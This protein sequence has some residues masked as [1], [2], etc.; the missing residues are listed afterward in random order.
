MAVLDTQ[1]GGRQLL[2]RTGFDG[3]L[4]KVCSWYNSLVTILFECTEGLWLSGKHMR[5]GIKDTI[6]GIYLP[7][8]RQRLAG[9]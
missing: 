1:I 9:L 3:P 2:R 8:H 6:I 5:S 7:I 4:G